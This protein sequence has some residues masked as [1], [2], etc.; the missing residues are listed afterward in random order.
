MGGEMTNPSKIGL[1]PFFAN[2]RCH[3]AHVPPQLPI[4]RTAAQSSQET[5]CK[6]VNEMEFGWGDEESDLRPRRDRF[7]APAVHPYK[8]IQVQ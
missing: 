1:A 4:K 6:G 8:N 3:I 7:L 5:I 2:P